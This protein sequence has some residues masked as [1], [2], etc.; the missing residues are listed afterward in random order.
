MGEGEAHPGVRHTYRPWGEL[1]ISWRAQQKDYPPMRLSVAQVRLV[2]R[3]RGP[4]GVKVD[5]RRE[6]NRSRDSTY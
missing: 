4:L 6:L 5:S 2:E 1:C 3:E